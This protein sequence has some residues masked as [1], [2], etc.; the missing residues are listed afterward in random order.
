MVYFELNPNINSLIPHFLRI[1][2]DNRAAISGTMLIVPEI[3]PIYSPWRP[4]QIA[5]LLPVAG[6]DR[7]KID[8]PARNAA[9]LS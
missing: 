9:G 5:D 7:I 3:W 2:D 8:S 1:Y 6:G 4:I